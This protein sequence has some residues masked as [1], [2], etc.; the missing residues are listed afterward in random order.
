M[1]E[2]LK[3]RFDFLKKSEDL[4]NAVMEV[5]RNLKENIIGNAKRSEFPPIEIKEV[6]DEYADIVITNKVKRKS[7]LGKKYILF[8]KNSILPDHLKFISQ[9]DVKA[10]IFERNFLSEYEEKGKFEK[11]LKE[12]IR[13]AMME[14]ELNETAF[15]KI[16]TWKF[17][18]REGEAT[19]E[20]SLFLDESMRD[21]R[22][23]IMSIKNNMENTWGNLFEKAKELR[24]EVKELFKKGKFDEVKRKLNGISKEINRLRSKLS[25]YPSVLLTGPTGSGKSF[26]AKIISEVVMN[27]P[28]PLTISVPSIPPH[29]IDGELFGSVEGAYTDARTRPGAMLFKMGGVVFLDEIAEVPTEIQSKLLVYMSNLIVKPEG[30]DIDFPAPVFLIAA[31]NRNIEKEI[32]KGNFREDLYHRFRWKI[33]MPSLEDRRSEIRF[34]ISFILVNRIKSL[35]KN[36]KEFYITHRAIQKLENRKYPG[37]FRE[38]ES[39]ISEAVENAISAERTII[40]ERDIPCS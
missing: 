33:R 29:I 38:L 31:T 5:Y 3:I 16:V 30:L 40:L 36:P 19:V 37:N 24:N 25:T 22:K 10:V 8:V 39:V 6:S 2:A 9:H 14:K 21:V 4:E 35:G 27:D 28:E 11:A 17:D 15:K 1:G 32:E 12:L 34:L 26:L 20:A 23:K 7:N 18:T 13:E